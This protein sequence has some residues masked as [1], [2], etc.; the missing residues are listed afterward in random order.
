MAG[1]YRA[2]NVGRSY[3]AEF[4][5][6]RANGLNYFGT[7]FY[8]LIQEVNTDFWMVS[9]KPSALRVHRTLEMEFQEEI[10]LKPVLGRRYLLANDLVVEIVTEETVNKHY[11]WVATYPYNDCDYLWLSVDINDNYGTWG[12]VNGEGKFPDVPDFDIVKCLSNGLIE[13]RRLAP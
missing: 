12:R 1:A 13:F 6:L 11:G 3:V 5:T 4:I 10:K 7:S 2:R 9:M 8:D